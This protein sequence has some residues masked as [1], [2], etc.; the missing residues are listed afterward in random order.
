MD[1]IDEYDSIRKRWT[2]TGIQRLVGTLRVVRFILR[3]AKAK[4]DKRQVKKK[5]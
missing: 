3:V 1:V 4:R 5:L 2:T